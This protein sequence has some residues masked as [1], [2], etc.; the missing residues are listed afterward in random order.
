MMT[1][2]VVEEGDDFIYLFCK[3]FKCS[4]PAE[5]HAQKTRIVEYPLYSADCRKIPEEY[6]CSAY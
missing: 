2:G 6:M 1:E 4:S 3:D 5:C